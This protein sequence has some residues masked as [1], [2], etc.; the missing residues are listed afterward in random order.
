MASGAT[1]PP[2]V[3]AVCEAGALGSLGAAMTAPAALRE[4]VAAIRE[5]TARPFNINLFVLRPFTPDPAQVARA[6]AHLQPLRQRFSLPDAPPPTRFGED[7]AAQFETLVELRVP[8][9]SFTFDILTA[10]EIERLHGAGSFVIGTATS[11]EEAR[12]WEAVGA[13]AVVVQGSEAGGHR[14]S[15]AHDFE[16]GM[17]GTLAL[18]PQVVDAVRLPVIAA[19]GIMDG[20]GI[21]AALAL[22]AGC[23][24]MGSVFLRTTESG[25]ATAWKDALGKAA[26]TSTRVSRNYTGRPARGIDN[27]LRRALEPFAADLPP[28]PVQS[29][30]TAEIRA[31]AARANEAE[32]LTLWAGQ[33][34]GMARVE[35]TR[36]VM[37][38]LERELREALAGL[39]A[40]RIA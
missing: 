33:A 39:G 18:V 13:D 16:A 15:F 25:I 27:A 5:K 30:L 17:V 29:A 32:Y 22:G 12:A 21:A 35:S 26:D 2:L 14:G 40:R 37:T 36:E 3:A 31:A 1:N 7:F 8:V 6:W 11:A 20:R 19:G 28:L 38:R 23:A 10:Q 4:V 9:A 34:A 24:Q